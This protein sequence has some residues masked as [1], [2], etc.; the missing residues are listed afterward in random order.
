MVV[1]IV[2]LASGGRLACGEALGGCWFGGVVSLVG[3]V[4]C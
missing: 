2:G 4:S 1:G 3:A